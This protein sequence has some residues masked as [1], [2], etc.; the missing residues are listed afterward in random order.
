[1]TAG[2]LAATVAG[3][4]TVRRQRSPEQSVRISAEAQ[5]AE[6]VS[7]LRDRYTTAA[8]QLGRDAPAIRLAGAYALAVL[9]AGRTCVTLE[10]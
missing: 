4:I 5:E 9:A 6:V 7:R 8:G 2:V 10:Q 1:M 3:A